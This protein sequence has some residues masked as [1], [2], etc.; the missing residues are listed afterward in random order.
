MIPLRDRQYIRIV[1]ILIKYLYW[2]GKI[3]PIRLILVGSKRSP[4]VPWH[5]LVAAY[6]IA[7]ATG[8][9][10]GVLLYITA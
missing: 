6:D 7:F 4:T 10:F 8:F 2:I 3:T 1:L 5:I 9:T